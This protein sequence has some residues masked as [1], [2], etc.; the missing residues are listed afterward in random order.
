MVLNAQVLFCDNFIQY[1]IV[2]LIGLKHPIQ[3]PTPEGAIHPHFAFILAP[4]P[5]SEL[6]FSAA[7][8]RSI[9]TQ[10]VVTFLFHL[11][12]RDGEACMFCLI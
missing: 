3:Q 6:S 10:T 12:Y 11:L 4:K 5:L 1:L 8:Q 9:R 2:L 7:A